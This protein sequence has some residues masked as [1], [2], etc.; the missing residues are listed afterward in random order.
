[1]KETYKNNQNISNNII[2]PKTKLNL[3]D[4]N[5]QKK[6][7]YSSEKSISYSSSVDDKN[8][9]IDNRINDS[10]S[11]F[12]YSE[13]LRVSEIPKKDINN[14]S[15]ISFEKSRNFLTNLNL[16]VSGN[17]EPLNFPRKTNVLCNNN[18]K[19]E[20]L[21]LKRTQSDDKFIEK[22]RKN[23]LGENNEFSKVVKIEKKNININKNINK[24]LKDNN[25]DINKENISENKNKN[26]KIIKRNKNNA[27]C[28]NIHINLSSKTANNNLI[29]PSIST[30]LL[31][32]QQKKPDQVKQKQPLIKKVIMNNYKKMNSN[33]SI[34]QQQQKNQR[35]TH[36]ES[37]KEKNDLN[38]PRLTVP[39]N[40][41]N[42]Q[43]NLNIKY[44]NNHIQSKSPKNCIVKKLYPLDINN[45]INNTKEKK[46]ENNLTEIN[47]NNRSSVS[48]N[49]Y[50]FFGRQTL[51]NYKNNNNPLINSMNI[52]HHMNIQNHH[53]NIQNHLIHRNINNINPQ[54]PKKNQLIKNFQY[55][56]MDNPLIISQSPSHQRMTI[57]T[58]TT[59]S[60]TQNPLINPIISNNNSLFSPRLT[61]IP[62]QSYIQ[63]PQINNNPPIILH[64]QD[65]NTIL[66]NLD[67]YIF[68]ENKNQVQSLNFAEKIK[69]NDVNI[70]YN[71]FDASGYMKNY[72]I[73]T[74]P[75]KDTSGLQKTNQDSFTF[76][77]NINGINNFNIFG[78][79]DGHG[80]E[81]HFVSKFCSKYIPYQIINNPE[82]K[83][84][85]DPDLIYLKLRSNN[86]HIIQKSYIDCDN[87]LSKVTN[88]SSQESGCT[89]NLIFHIGK[90]II[91]AN[92]GDS[93]AILVHEENINN[94]KAKPLSIDFKPEMIEEMN[95]IIISGGEV[96][97]MKNDLGEGIGPF[98]VWKKGEGYP[99]LAMSRS[100]GD[101]IGKKIG[102]IPNPGILEYELNESVKFIVVCS[103]GV[104]EFLNNDEVKNIGIN[105][106][107]KN[108]PSKFCHELVNTS[109]NLWEKNDIVVDDITAVVAF[110]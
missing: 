25:K 48:P 46:I 26:E 59:P 96:R 34:S 39:I 82:I 87:A 43:I 109:L 68:P 40:K 107:N 36:I 13:T 78:V 16:A 47:S 89:C 7:I 103:D 35:L 44:N 9:T 33:P 62:T 67:K 37:I 58:L 101:L 12:D 64:N 5:K 50:Q 42:K 28:K 97:Q 57:S 69:K 93:R 90:H 10:T 72:G 91:C 100:I 99:G 14:K 51:I 75:G 6:I 27:I 85:K 106:Y 84:L 108:D 41:N 30:L 86:Y 70:T 61:N 63:I 94:Y 105:F 98:R 45:I 66:N 24:N 17:L 104:W 3:D 55:E 71:K 52:D 1:M 56:K 92:T 77:T 32:K 53:M 102:V 20:N 31:K 23:K 4:S 80:L 22:I 21:I 95:R 11:S 65:L 76:I 73:L 19:D 2:I 15:A 83:N 54:I 18:K 49:P 79:L 74:L 88:F 38:I 81:G 110:F 29:S 8:E 60:Q